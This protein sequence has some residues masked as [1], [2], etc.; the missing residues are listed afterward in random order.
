MTNPRHTVMV[1]F[2]PASSDLLEKSVLNTMAAKLAPAV[3]DNRTHPMVHAELFFPEYEIE[4]TVGGE[5]CGIHY[6]GTVFMA[7]K[8]FSRKNWLFRSIGVTQE[9]RDKLRNFCRKQVGGGFNYLGYYAPCSLFSGTDVHND[10][11]RSWY[12]SEL[13]ASALQ[14]AN[15]IDMDGNAH[16]HPELLYQ[17]VL[18]ASFADCGR[19]V[20][21]SKLQL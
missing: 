4:D 20:Q 11:T 6:G 19:T 8:T 15:V 10:Q 18:D 2:L 16:L 9:Q 14:H 13:A 1:C 5:S 21:F 17:A 3:T 7:P 12:C